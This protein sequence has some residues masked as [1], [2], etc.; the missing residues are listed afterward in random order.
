MILSE[1]ESNGAIIFWATNPMPRT[2]LTQIMSQLT[3]TPKKIKDE[4]PPKVALKRA[5]VYIHPKKLIDKTE[6]GFTVVNSRKGV[7]VN[8]YDD[9]ESVEA[10]FTSTPLSEWE[11]GLQ[12]NYKIQVLLAAKA[13]VGASLKHY[14]IES[15]S[16][17]SIRPA[18]GMYW[19]PE[20][21]C[22]KWEQAGQLFED[23]GTVLYICRTVLNTKTLIGIED[24]MNREL[25]EIEEEIAKR[26]E[27]NLPATKTQHMNLNSYR[28]KLQNYE[29]SLHSNLGRIQTRL[30]DTVVLVLQSRNTA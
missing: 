1:I 28:R 8:N 25:D 9:Q 17:I 2:N 24:A 26:F 10:T 29:Q 5:L 22:D 4:T 3:T 16:G 27:A 13:E 6:K 23:S 21:S 7:T 18:G 20:Y 19:I 12:E 14:A 11:P 30:A 15:L